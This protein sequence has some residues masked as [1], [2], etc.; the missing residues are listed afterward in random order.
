MERCI[1]RT[2]AARKAWETRK[3][4][5]SDYRPARPFPQTDPEDVHIYTL[6]ANG[7]T[8]ARAS[9]TSEQAAYLN[10]LFKV[11][12]EPQLWTA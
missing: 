11:R 2:A 10:E 3:A 7:F 1:D 6:S 4:Q 9:I 12:R 5:R 8:I